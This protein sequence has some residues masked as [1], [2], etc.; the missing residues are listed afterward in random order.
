MSTPTLK[1]LFLS[2]STA[3]KPFARRLC[4]LL[5]AHGVKVWFDEAEIRP[6]DL[7]L[8]KVTEG[9]QQCAY[10]GVVLS[11][12]S[13]KSTWVKHEL[14]MA[15]V[16]WHDQSDIVI[17]PILAMDCEI[18]LFLRPIRYID[19]RA[20]EKFQ[21]GLMEIVEMLAPGHVRAIRQTI[22]SAVNAEIEA[23][24]ALPLVSTAKLLEVFDPAGPALSRILTTLEEHRRKGNIITNP[25]NPSDFDVKK[26]RITR[27]SEDEAEVKTTE[28]VFLKWWS[29]Q[30]RKYVYTWNEINRQKY[31]LVRINGSWFVNRNIY[32]PARNPTQPGIK[33]FL[34][35]K[36]PFLRNLKRRVSPLPK[37]GI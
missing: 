1:G 33:G 3:D 25:S 15:F 19:F 18:P 21:S 16:K 4:R 6:G 9:I 13:V 31:L 11:P 34:S 26:I 8:D 35:R 17:I 32:P 23:Y 36:F 22:Q 5:R 30:K 20:R 14:A 2:H 7:L 28:F 12:N 27:L 37:R 24:R 29:T 10:L